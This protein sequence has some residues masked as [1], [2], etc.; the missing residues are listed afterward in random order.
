MVVL[1]YAVE[2]RRNPLV[3]RAFVVNDENLRNKLNEKE[4]SDIPFS[5]EHPPVTLT[6]KMKKIPWGLAERHENVC[7]KVPE[8]RTPISGEEEI[9]LYPYGCSKLRMTEMPIV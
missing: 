9:E 1:H 5:S 8:S 2:H 3:A 6:A 7:A 4:I